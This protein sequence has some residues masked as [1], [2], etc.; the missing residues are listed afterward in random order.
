MPELFFKGKEFVFDHQLSPPS[1]GDTRPLRGQ[2][3]AIPPGKRSAPPTGGFSALS[4]GQVGAAADP[5]DATGTRRAR[6]LR[7]A[8][9]Q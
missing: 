1:R 5:A 6:S 9:R 3:G 4:H 7:P 2:L 8:I